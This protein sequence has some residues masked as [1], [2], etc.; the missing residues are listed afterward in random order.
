MYFFVKL[1]A[2]WEA[3]DSD[4]MNKSCGLGI[5][6]A[7]ILTNNLR[8]EWSK[9]KATNEAN[10]N[11]KNQ[12]HQRAIRPNGLQHHLGGEGLH[13]SGRIWVV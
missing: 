10:Q 12:A 4:W 13:V 6:L 2:P 11:Q 8:G 1:V 5:N 3:L 7:T 9:E